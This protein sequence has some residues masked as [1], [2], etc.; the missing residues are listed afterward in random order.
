MKQAAAAYLRSHLAA[1]PDEEA[2]LEFDGDDDELDD[3]GP[4]VDRER[5]VD[6]VVHLLLGGGP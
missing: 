1:R 5:L 6:H 3:N 2:F 4:I